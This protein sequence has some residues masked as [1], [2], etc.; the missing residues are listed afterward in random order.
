MNSREIL[1]TECGV[2]GVLIL[3]LLK[4][5]IKKGFFCYTPCGAHACIVDTNN[6][7]ERLERAIQNIARDTGLKEI[8]KMKKMN[9]SE[10]DRVLSNLEKGVHRKPYL[11]KIDSL[12]SNK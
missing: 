10:F 4:I 11:L 7:N 6:G 9:K 1:Y 5:M 8:K 3:C 2:V 12:R